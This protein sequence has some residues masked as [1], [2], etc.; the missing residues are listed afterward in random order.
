MRR[1]NTTFLNLRAT[2]DDLDPLVEDSKPVAKKLRPFM[3]ELRPLARDARPTFR[4][5]ADISP[6]G[7][8]QR[9]GRADGAAPL[10]DETAREVEAN[11]AER[12]AA[13]PA[14]TTR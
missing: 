8:G 3:A 7:R 4:D 9:P 11:G 13:F 2:L 10:R 12:R 5:L 14:L 1:A 6:P